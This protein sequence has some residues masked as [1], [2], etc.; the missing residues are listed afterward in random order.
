MRC[1]NIVIFA[2]VVTR[3]YTVS[4]GSVDF[5]VRMLFFLCSHLFV[6]I[7]CDDA[8]KISKYISVLSKNP[9]SN[10]FELY[11]GNS[12]F[13]VPL[14]HHQHRFSRLLA[15]THSVYARV[16]FLFIF[17]LLRCIHTITCMYRCTNNTDASK[18]NERNVNR[19]AI[20]ELSL[21][22]FMHKCESL[23]AIHFVRSEI[24]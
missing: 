13:Y 21:S 8:V 5:H 12:N 14:R 11:S 3:V 17:R 19:A 24:I 9:N 18:W 20:L 16:F 22:N 1:Q 6:C 15:R 2:I 23:F 7:K 4:F 10:P